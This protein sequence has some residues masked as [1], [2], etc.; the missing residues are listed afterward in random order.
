VSNEA[1]FDI[2]SVDL[3]EVDNAQQVMKEINGSI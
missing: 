2:N 3:Q 1:S